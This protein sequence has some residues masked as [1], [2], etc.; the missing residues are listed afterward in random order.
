MDKP[1]GR[2]KDPPNT[3]RKLLNRSRISS[4]RKDTINFD[5]SPS[6]GGFNDYQKLILGLEYSLEN[7]RKKSDAL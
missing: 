3:D 1:D 4:N 5:G 7:E 6:T 2:K